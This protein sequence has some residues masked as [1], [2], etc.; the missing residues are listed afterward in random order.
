MNKAR[1]IAFYLP[2]FHPIPENDLWWGKGFTEW[3]NVA[4]AKPQFR[5]HVQPKIPADL[6]F[7]D[8][9]L[10]EVREAQAEMARD[11]GVEGFCYWHYWFG[12][13]K[14][15]LERPFNEVLSSGKPDFPFCLGWANHSWS[16]KTWQKN[17]TFQKDTMFMEQLYGDE[18]DYVKHFY[19]ILPA[20]KDKRYIT[21]DGKPLFFIF[22][23]IGFPDLKKFTELWRKLAIENGVKG[24]DFV[25]KTASVGK[26]DKGVTHDYLSDA[27]ERYDSV[28][29]KGMDAVNSVNLRRAELLAVGKYSKMM[30]RL[31]NKLIPSSKVEKYDYRKIIQHLLTEE[32]KEE[33]IYPT[34]LP[35]WD[36]TPRLGKQAY[37]YINSTPELFEKSVR[38]AVDFVKNKEPEHR[39]I[40]L[41]AWN[42]WG[43]GNFM[44]P[45]LEFG[46]GY[47]DAL[48]RVICPD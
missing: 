19:T 7:Y 13:G 46:H 31:L 29:A 33:N 23:P 48:K 4:K 47:L 35:R 37:V 16:N 17:T 38:Q 41:Q 21:V 28:L 44:E 6:G 36:K 39:I 11:C 22:D 27:R 32:D 34:I 5:G 26:F 24:I 10:P 3:T 43:E 9:R 40:F 25:G 12:N 18:T 30:D 8:L 15:L 45:D 42:E 2:Q 1:V 20:F 14:T